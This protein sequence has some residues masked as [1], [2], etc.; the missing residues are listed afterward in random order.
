MMAMFC[1]CTTAVLAIS[2]VP[3][4]TLSTVTGIEPQIRRA[5]SLKTIEA[6]IALDD[7]P[8]WACSGQ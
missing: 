4:T 1:H 8:D 5:P 7:G 2:V 3:L 6:P